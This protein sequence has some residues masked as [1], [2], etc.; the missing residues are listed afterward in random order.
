MEHSLKHREETAELSTIESDLD[1]V[2]QQWSSLVHSA[3]EIIMLVLSDGR[4]IYTNRPWISETVSGTVGS[5][6]LSQIPM[7]ER[8]KVSSCLARTFEFGGLET[9]VVGLK[10]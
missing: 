8:P 1:Q 6:L 4:I 7:E 10:S 5:D 2:L 9:C 3:P